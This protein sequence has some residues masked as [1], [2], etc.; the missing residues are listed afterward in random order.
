MAIIL[1]IE[2]VAIAGAAALVEPVSAPANYKDAAKI[3][4]YI[5]EA[6]QAQIA[7]AALYPWTAKIAAL[8]YILDSGAEVV[9]LCK[10]EQD[11]SDALRTFWAH[12]YRDDE[13]FV[14]PI[15]GF[16][17]RSFDLPVLLARSIL[18]GI[19][20]PALNLDRYRTPHTD[21]MD[22]LTWFGAIPARSL[23]WYAKR[24]GLTVEDEISGKD[25]GALVASGE[26]EAVASHCLSDVRLTKALAERVGVIRGGLVAA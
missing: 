12:V 22:K 11:E 1:D 15:V 24:F 25:I 3:A 17:H 19:K 9:A 4:A 7:K 23:K 14:R 5:E 21:V 10:D 26:W 13:R 20:A 6:Q 16:N 2:T 18:L 8:G